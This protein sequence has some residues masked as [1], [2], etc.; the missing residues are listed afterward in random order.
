MLLDDDDDFDP[1]SM[2][3]E[4]KSTNVPE[5]K[6]TDS[7]TN[8]SLLHHHDATRR[9]REEEH[10]QNQTTQQQQPKPPQAI[11]PSTIQQ[12]ATANLVNNNNVTTY[13]PLSVASPTISSLSP[14]S[15]IG[16]GTS[17]SASSG[18][19]GG[20]G[21]LATKYIPSA[22][23]PTGAGGA[24]KKYVPST[25]G[26]VPPSSPAVMN[27]ISVGGA[28]GG[29]Q[30]ASAMLNTTA[31]QAKS[32]PVISVGGPSLS[33]SSSFSSISLSQQSLSQQ[34]KSQQ[35]Q[36][37]P[38]PVELKN[39]L[40]TRFETTVKA[41]WEK[42]TINIESD[43][44]KLSFNDLCSGT[45]TALL[46]KHTNLPKET[47]ESMIKLL[48]L[49]TDDVNGPPLCKRLIIGSLTIPEFVN[50]KL[51][52]LLSE[53]QKAIDEQERQEHLLSRDQAFLFKQTMMPCGPFF[54]CRRC[55]SKECMMEQ[56]QTSRGDEGTT[57]FITC[58][59]CG[60]KW[61]TRQ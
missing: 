44:K 31:N 32:F 6:T 43:K 13:S 16:V 39:K 42:F 23:L 5:Q 41:S 14:A 38:N 18:S 25:A 33:R 57:C 24:V 60:L 21:T 54:K 52:D 48:G 3:N 46:T 49:L 56:K 47:S 58:T 34:Q 22:P 20:A 4:L 26:K 2:L 11:F 50:A 1:V 9:Q 36:Q 8:L 55:G 17:N 45:V 15:T 40:T 29:F 30:A 59:E 10:H 53:E 28:G 19:T 61:K 51:S 27:P 37:Q 12:V 35:Q 7:A